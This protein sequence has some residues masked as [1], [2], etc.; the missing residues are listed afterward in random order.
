MKCLMGLVTISLCVLSSSCSDDATIWSAKVDSPNGQLIATAQTV[1]TSGPGN[2][3]VGTAVYLKQPLS[4]Y[5]PVMVLG[6][7]DE[8]AYPVGVTAVELHWQSNSKLDVTYKAGATIEF[9]AVKALG[10]DISVH[11]VSSQ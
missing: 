9:Q 6:L 4:S 2:N 11:Q 7:S 5:P 8:S 3:S 1:Q 10:A